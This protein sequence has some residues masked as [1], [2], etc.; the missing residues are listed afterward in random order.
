[1]KIKAAPQIEN[2]TFS[3][4]VRRM[5]GLDLGWW[6]TAMLVSLGMAAFAAVAVLITTRA[7]ILLQDQEAKDNEDAFARYKLEVDERTAQLNK[8]AEQLKADNLAL[9]KTIAPRRWYGPF[10]GSVRGGPTVTSLFKMMGLG[11]ELSKYPKT[12][13]LIQFV[14]DFDA[15]KLAVLISEGLT[16]VGWSPQLIE[17]AQ[18]GISPLAIPDGVQLWTRAEHDDAWRAAE[19]LAASLSYEGIEAEKPTA[20]LHRDDPSQIVLP[21][22]DIRKSPPVGSVVI[23]I[24]EKPGFLE[25][26]EKQGD[27]YR[28]AHTDEK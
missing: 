1:M 20:K 25:L 21:N 22:G 6:N 7:V 27:E 19:A 23:L 28:A 5:L 12:S 24:G 13:A 15:Q 14:P 3:K 26:L 4:R 10:S 9:E 11:S 8:E 17:A 18:S 2:T 16:I